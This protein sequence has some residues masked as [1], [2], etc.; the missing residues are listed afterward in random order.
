MASTKPVC[1]S[2]VT[3]PTEP[4]EVTVFRQ[5]VSAWATG[6]ERDDPRELFDRF[7]NTVSRPSTPATSP[8]S[9]TWVVPIHHYRTR[10]CDSSKSR[11]KAPKFTARDLAPAGGQPTKAL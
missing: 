3:S 9:P 5:V 10:Q 1:A 8:V 6:D 2:E 4:A 7:A 11:R